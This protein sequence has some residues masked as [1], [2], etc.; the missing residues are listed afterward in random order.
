MIATVV[1]L[2]TG[3]LIVVC[4]AGNWAFAAVGL[5]VAAIALGRVTVWRRRDNTPITRDQWRRR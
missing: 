5:I 3:S 1:L 2:V 4:S